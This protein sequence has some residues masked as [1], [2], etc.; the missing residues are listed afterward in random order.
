MKQK[1]VRPKPEQLDR[2]RRPCCVSGWQ[3]EHIQC[4][5]YGYVDCNVVK[6][7]SWSKLM[8]KLLN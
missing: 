6:H 8:V 7:T 1:V 4:M 3:A 2:L 5:R